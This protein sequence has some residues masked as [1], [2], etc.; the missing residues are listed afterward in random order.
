MGVQYV[1]VLGRLSNGAW[2]PSFLAN[3]S[4]HANTMSAGPV[5]VPICEA[6]RGMVCTLE[7]TTNGYRSENGLNTRSTKLVANLHPKETW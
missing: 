6:S 5:Q 7:L 1:S 4:N 2:F 3:P